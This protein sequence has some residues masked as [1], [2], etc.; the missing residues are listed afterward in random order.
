MKSFKCDDAIEVLG[1]VFNGVNE[2]LEY[3]RKKEPKDGVYV[4]E[5][6]ERYPCFDRSDYLYENRRYT[7]LVFA[8]TREELEL[9]LLILS[10]M[11]VLGGNYK[12]LTGALHPMLYWAGDKFYDVLLTE[13]NEIE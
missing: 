11:D 6:S 10:E 12:K 4:G 1:V 7:N 13:N 2:M 8:T 5:D 3:A 9:K